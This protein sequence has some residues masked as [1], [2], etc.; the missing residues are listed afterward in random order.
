MFYYN[1]TFY[2]ENSVFQLW[3]NWLKEEGISYLFSQGN[4]RSAKLLHIQIPEKEAQSYSVQLET[5]D[6]QHIKSFQQQ[7]EAKFRHL[8]F[9]QFGEAV[10]PFATELH[11]KETIENQKHNSND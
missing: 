5:T 11:L 6:L 7:H 9:K 1:I 8:L 4:F 3:K 2:I 10:L